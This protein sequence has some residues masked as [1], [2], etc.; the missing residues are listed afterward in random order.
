MTRSTKCHFIISIA[1]IT[2]KYSS[3]QKVRYFCRPVMRWMSSPRLSLT[4]THSSNV[5]RIRICSKNVPESHK[6]TTRKWMNV[7]TAQWKLSQSW[8]LSGN[9]HIL[10]PHAL[11]D[12]KSL[13]KSFGWMH[14]WNTPLRQC[15]SYTRWTSSRYSHYTNN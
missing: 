14:T 5:Y 6:S 12:E 10:L 2:R 1:Y 7:Y 8:S 9:T 11:F 13:E 3:L 4:K 15:V